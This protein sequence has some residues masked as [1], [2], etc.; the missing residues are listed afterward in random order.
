MVA[1]P[2][3]LV[4]FIR[5]G[6]RFIVAGH[7]EPD[8]DCVGSQLALSSLL[9]RLG[10]EAVPC[11]AGPFKRPEV[12]PYEKYFLPCPAVSP[13][14]AGVSAGAEGN[15]GS[16]GAGGGGNGGG[17]SG[18]EGFRVIVMDCSSRERVGD[19][20]IDGLPSAAVD[21]HA[22]GNPWG[23]VVYLDP[24]APS[25]T[26]MTARLFE[27]LGVEINR[28]EAEL[29]FFGLC[30]DTG[31][32]RH[33]DGGPAPA[34]AFKT[35]ALLTAAG[36]SAKKTFA[37]MQGGKTLASRLLMGTVLA[38]TR[39]Y[40]GG[41]LLVSDETL[42]ESKRFGLESRDSDTIYQLLQSVEGAEAM[43]LLRQENPEECTL[44]LRSRDRINVAAVAETFGGGGH[45]NAAGAKVPG[46]I[47]GLEEQIVLAFAP[48]FS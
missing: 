1:V 38:K 19:L 16:S 3:A 43:V 25:V 35:A 47:A 20:P 36:A 10:K 8:G 24:E 39:A 12:K 27:A 7:E 28:E 23:R 14:G 2:E 21:H 37:A 29:L 31:F 41:R 33:L 46:L 40:Y 44:G 6:R 11:S 9:S 4:A 5:E 32:F 30:T 26:L 18:A 15:G 48:A 13:G 45:K 17:S 22:S 42:E 34:E